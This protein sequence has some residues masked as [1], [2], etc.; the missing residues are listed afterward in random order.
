MMKL[1]WPLGSIGAQERS[2]FILMNLDLWTVKSRLRR[3]FLNRSIS[4]CQKKGSWEFEL[5]KTVSKLYRA[6]KRPD[7]KQRVLTSAC[8]EYTD[9]RGPEI[10]IAFGNHWEIVEDGWNKIHNIIE[11]FCMLLI[12]FILEGERKVEITIIMTT[13]AYSRSKFKIAFILWT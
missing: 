1:R 10:P 5:V 4:C 8:A 3:N 7:S 13:I 6:Q 11:S 9:R 2:R 12:A